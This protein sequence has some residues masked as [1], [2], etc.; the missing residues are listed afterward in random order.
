M[1]RITEQPS[2]YRH[3]EKMSVDELVTNINREDQ[4][5]APAIEKELPKIGK[6]I[7]AI[8]GQLRAG[9]RLIYLGAGSGGRLSVLDKVELPNTF[10]IEKGVVICLLA[11]GEENLLQVLEEKED[12][13][14]D[15]LRQMELYRVNEKDFVLGISASGSTPYVLEGL[16][17]CKEL[18]IPCGCIVNNPNSPIAAA[19]DYPIE[20][21][22]GPEFISGSTRM[23]CGTVQKMLFDMISTTVFIRLGRI[24][25]NRMVNVRLINNKAI[26]RSVKMLQE[27]RNID[28]YEEAKKLV[29][30]FGS[31]KKAMDFIDSQQ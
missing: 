2:L 19:C 25:D 20:V 22:T 23:K 7:T 13:T 6:M 17:R 4:K 3:L 28:N 21:V 9:G 30:D 26:D 11:G 27:K 31:V 15:A 1:E 14:E 8:E 24:E 5:V 18:N 29:I 16:K 10:G 12:D